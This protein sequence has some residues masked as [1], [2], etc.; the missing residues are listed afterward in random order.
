MNHVSAGAAMREHGLYCERKGGNRHYAR[1]GSGVGSTGRGVVCSAGM[2]VQQRQARVREEGK[3]L[4]E[5]RI[6][7]SCQRNKQDEDGKGKDGEQRCHRG[8]R[9]LSQG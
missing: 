4:N 1:K 7:A 3:N 8:C 9:R 5:H 2:D 6:V